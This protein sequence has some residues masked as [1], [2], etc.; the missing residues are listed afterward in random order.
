MALLTAWVW[1]GEVP[2]LLSLMGGVLVL[3]GV[4]VVHRWGRGRG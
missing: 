3:A 2:A 4:I 1:L